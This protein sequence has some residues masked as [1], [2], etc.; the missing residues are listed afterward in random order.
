MLRLPLTR[1][2]ILELDTCTFVSCNTPADSKFRKLPMS[3]LSTVI[4]VNWY[5]VAS[6]TVTFPAFT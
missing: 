5:N 1:L 2:A 4:L 3:L 6:E